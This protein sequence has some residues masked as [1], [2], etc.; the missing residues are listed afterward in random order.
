MGMSN[1]AYDTL[2]FIALLV[3]PI[4][5]LVG[6]LATVW[7]FPYGDKIVATLV[8]IDVFLGA[9]VKVSSDNYHKYE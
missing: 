4:S 3:L 9:V 2:K 6:S 1:K 8:A 5:E 7:G